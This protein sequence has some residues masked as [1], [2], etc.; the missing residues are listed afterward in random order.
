MK[1]RRSGFSLVLIGLLGVAFFWLTDP[2]Y[3]WPRLRGGGNA[4]DAAHDAAIAT[5]VGIIGCGLIVLIGLW[6]LA[7][8]AA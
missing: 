2:K 6:L 3:G 4:I 7:R 1:S 5:Y 8:R